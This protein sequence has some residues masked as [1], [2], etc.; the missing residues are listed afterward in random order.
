MVE[1]FANYCRQNFKLDGSLYAEPYYSLPICIIDCIYSLRTKYFPVC[2]TVINRYAF[3]Y[4]E[5]Y[6]QNTND[7][8]SN[9]IKHIDEVGG[10]KDFAEKILR[11]RQ[12]L[13]GRLKSEICYELAQKLLTLNINSLEDFQNY[14][15]TAILETVIRSVK[16]I[17][18]AGLNYLF[19][20]AGDPNRCKPDVHI[21][22]C[23]R[24]A[25]GKD[26]SDEE[27]QNLFTNTVEILKVDFPNLTVR[28]LD[29]IIW[30][31]YQ[32]K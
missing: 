18:Q 26:I 22:H 12:K 3:A 2:V 8:L 24:D 9:F 27:C 21:H 16:G 10:C 4:M 5:N 23:V 1:T 17:G 13:S 6:R 28:K 30:E 15:N 7:Y 11:N 25:C 20:L 31:K 14:D 29:G 32:A 19:M